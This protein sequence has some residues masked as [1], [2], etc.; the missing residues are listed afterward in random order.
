PL[1]RRGI[2]VSIEPR[3]FRGEMFSRHVVG[4]INSALLTRLQRLFSGFSGIKLSF[5]KLMLKRG[6]GG[7][8]DVRIASMLEHAPFTPELVELF[9]QL[10]EIVERYFMK[11]IVQ[12]RPRR[13][14]DY[15][16]LAIP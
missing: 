8:V 2:R 16:A 3:S 7:G 6:G 12:S 13:Y 4:A 9:L 1:L 10:R 14:I 5:V 11:K 15:V